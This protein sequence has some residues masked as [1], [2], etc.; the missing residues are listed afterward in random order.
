MVCDN[1]LPGSN[2]V[3]SVSGVELAAKS[4]FAMGRETFK[5][6]YIE[7]QQKKNPNVRSVP[8]FPVYFSEFLFLTAFC[9]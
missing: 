2:Y 5:N 7:M 6:N 1:Q 4:G 9:Y 3:I 8:V